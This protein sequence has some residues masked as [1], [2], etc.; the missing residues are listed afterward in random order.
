MSNTIINKTKHRNNAVDLF[1]LIAAFMVV[2][3]HT[4]PFEDIS[5]SLGFL[6]CQVLVR[7]AVPFFFVISGYYYFIGLNKNGINY[8]IKYIKRLLIEYG[9][10]SL[11]YYI[12][13]FIQL[14]KGTSILSFI[15]SKIVNF[16]V[17][18]SHY[19]L[20]FYPALIMAI[21]II[22]LAYKLNIGKALFW[23]TIPLYI[24]G[25]ISTTYITKMPD[26]LN[27]VFNFT[28]FEAIRRIFLIG[29]PFCVLGYYLSHKKSQNEEQNTSKIT[30]Y[31]IISALA[32]TI[33]TAVIL[34][35]DIDAIISTFSLYPLVAFIVLRLLQIEKK[36]AFAEIFRDCSTFIYF[37]H[38][39]I[40]WLF[41][42]L[43]LRINLNSTTTL[44]IMT[45][46]TSF[47][48]AYIYYKVK[49]IVKRRKFSK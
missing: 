6:V 31:F 28:Y 33:E 30:K 40:I 7:V 22:T 48:L 32:Y 17:F 29:L 37:V 43:F 36:I 14:S 27:R 49:K 41:K 26:F 38:P 34:I 11:I 4:N 1:R 24:L 42:E 3:I 45:C 18:G 9:I 20:W 35:L 19:H 39:L 8:A 13:D 46:I 2:A 15:K 47:T 23:I 44:W 10:W 5:N 12:I 25:C 16:A 21:V